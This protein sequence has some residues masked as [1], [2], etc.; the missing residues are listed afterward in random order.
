MRILGLD[1]G[2]KT[3]GVALSDELGYTAQPLTVLT[4]RGGNRDLEAVAAL[5]REY[6]ARQIVLGLPLNMN[7]SLS[8]AAE[9]VQAFGERLAEFV[10]TSDLKAEVVYWDER[11]STVTA[12]RV[13]IQ[14]D[15]SRSRRKKVIDKLAASVILQGYLDRLAVQEKDA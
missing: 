2:S 7:G 1:L 14:A 13:L 4:R 10:T 12:E 8:P 15:L 6:E 9:Q 3:I 5:V 11:W